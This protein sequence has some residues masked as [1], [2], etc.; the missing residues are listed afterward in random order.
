MTQDRPPTAYQRAGPAAFAAGLLRELGVDPAAVSAAAGVDI[1][2]LTPDSRIAFA[3]LLAILNTGGALSGCAH[4]GALLGTRYPW[5]AHGLIHDL[6][7]QAPTLRQ[8]LLDFVTWQLGY[9]SGAVVYL[10]RS[11]DDLA[12]G[13]GVYGANSADNR[14]Y[15]ELCVAVGC[16]IVRELS[17]AAVAP[18][19]VHFMHDAAGD[20]A[21]LRQ[22]IG[23]PMRFSQPHCCLVLDAA[24]ID[25]PRPMA[26]PA[27]RAAAMAEVDAAL[28]GHRDAVGLRLRHLLRAQLVAEDCSLDGAAAA[29]G[30]TPRTL[31][32]RLQ[33]EGSGF[34]GL[35]DEVRFAVAREYLG[36]TCLPV[37]E[38]AAALAF[39]SH[40][41]F[42][43]AF[44]RWSGMSPTAWRRGAR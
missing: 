44:R 29:L 42:D 25:R 34:A 21:A 31:R 10:N 1:E 16:T 28:G 27:R 6:A 17:D 7:Q 12:L 3:E 32:R 4:F 33:A 35:L 13:I 19:E 5:P 23:A 40:S 2:A 20:T 15:Y 38:I 41:A 37:G 24:T 43:Q 8:G 39:A 36:M 30:L 11:G 9:S 14:H 18:L 26:D 22:I